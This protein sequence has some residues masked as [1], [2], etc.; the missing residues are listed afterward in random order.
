[1]L[2]KVLLVVSLPSTADRGLSTLHTHWVLPRVSQQVNIV[3]PRDKWDLAW[4]GG[5]SGCLQRH[6]PGEKPE[7]QV[8]GKQWG[9]KA[10]GVCTQRKSN[11]KAI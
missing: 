5:V 3:H 9:I 6:F 8:G 4:K 10:T 2:E 7:R 1:M 11:S